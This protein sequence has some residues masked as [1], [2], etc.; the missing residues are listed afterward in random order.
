M[1]VYQ[2]H[3]TQ[4][5]SFQPL[6][7]SY[8]STMESLLHQHYPWFTP[9]RP[10]VTLAPMKDLTTAPS[11]VAAYRAGSIGF[12]GAGFNLRTLEAEL[13]AAKDLLLQLPVNPEKGKTNST[14]P[15]PKAPQPPEQAYSYRDDGSVLPIG[16]GFQTWG[17][18]LNLALAALRKYPF[19]AVW[20]FAPK[21]LD[22]LS[23][24][25]QEIRE[26]EPRTQIWVQ[27]GSVSEATGLN[28]AGP[29]CP[30]VLVVQ[31]SDAGGHGL[32]QSASLLTLVPEVLDALWSQFCQIPV[33]AAGGI[34][35][36]RGAAAVLALGA[37]GV[38]MGT[39]FLASRE[40][41]IAKGY[42]DELLRASDGGQSTVRSVIYDTVRGI[43]GWPEAYDGRGVINESYTDAIAGM[44]DEAN[45]E[46]Y[47]REGIAKGD[48]G[49]GPTGRMT[50]YA[51]TGVGLVRDI[52]SIE[53]IIEEV[54]SDAKEILSRT[55]ERFA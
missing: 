33:L 44:S 28:T 1:L 55:V 18:D 9:S 5:F 16:V 50:T 42:Q 38:V 20:L 6:L 46:L 34:C 32:K 10:I 47:E 43:N 25:I 23:H 22:D 27:I 52:K 53:D 12:I 45:R 11:V 7:I 26:M 40:V 35:D 24:W 39:R 48:K 3:S 21:S 37:A 41:K 14:S 15:P 29:Q 13:A 31:G 30:D 4:L 36:G 54:S 8:Q 49:W 17:A 51:G 19:A 2:H